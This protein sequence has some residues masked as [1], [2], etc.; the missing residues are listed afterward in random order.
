MELLFSPPIAFLLYLGLL[1]LP[2]FRLRATSS[3]ETSVDNAA[4]ASGE[5]APNESAA[6]GY[7]AFSQFALFFAVF[8]LAV[9]L[10]ATGGGQIM[11]AVF[12]LFLMLLLL[13]ILL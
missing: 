1:A 10:L 11:T 5:I 3:G 9:L 13:V 8:H 12:L 7:Q 6:A 2:L 4:Y